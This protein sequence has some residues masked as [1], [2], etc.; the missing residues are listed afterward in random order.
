MIYSLVFKLKLPSLPTSHLSEKFRSENKTKPP[1][2]SER[3]VLEG[4]ELAL[5][6][7]CFREGRLGPQC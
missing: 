1:T 5:C 2:T 6:V 3:L 4:Q 7:C